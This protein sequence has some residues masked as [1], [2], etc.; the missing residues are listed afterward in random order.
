MVHRLDPR[1]K[2]LLSFCYIGLVFMANNPVSYLIIIAFTLGAILASKISLGF[3]LKGI[4]PLIWLIVFTVVLQLLFSPVGGH[5][6]FHWAFVNITQFGSLIGI[7]FGSVDHYDV[8]TIDTVHP[9]VGYCDRP[10]VV[11]E[12]FTLGSGPSR[13]VGDDAVDCVGLSPLMDE[14]IRL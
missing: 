13:H 9:T 1:A 7:L 8:H 12:T 11:D 3:F 14:P 4:R 10:S 2:L 6:Y 5:V